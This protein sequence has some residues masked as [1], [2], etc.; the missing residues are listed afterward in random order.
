MSWFRENVGLDGI[1]LAIHVVLTG[2]FLGFLGT[3]HVAPPAFPL[4]IGASLVILGIRRHRNLLR[5]EHVGLS[6][7]EM[8]VARLEEVEQRLAELE[9]AQGR[10][11]EL[12]ERLDFTERLLARQSEGEKIFPAGNRP[13]ELDR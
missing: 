10:I 11:L 7:G 12:E 2:L 8:T 5:R 6:T 13:P 4:T 9:A 3:I 1:D